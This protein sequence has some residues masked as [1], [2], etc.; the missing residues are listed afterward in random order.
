MG[1]TT[2]GE[3][4][5]EVVAAAK[6]RI[7]L[8]PMGRAMLVLYLLFFL[9]SSVM[10]FST[11]EGL[12]Y[13]Q[14]GGNTWYYLVRQA[15][16]FFGGL[17]LMVVV[18]QGRL[19]FYHRLDLLGVILMLGLLVLTL[20]FGVAEKGARRALSVFGLFTI[21]PAELASVPLIIYLASYFSDGRNNPRT[22][23][24]IL[25]PMVVIGA[26]CAVVVVNSLSQALVL[27]VVGGVMLLMGRVRW[28]Y[29]VLI[30]VMGLVG[31]GGY[32]VWSHQKAVQAEQRGEELEA[33]TTNRS[34][35][36]YNRFERWLNGTETQTVQSKMAIA[37]GVI[38]GKGPG[39]NQLS[40]L[41][42]ESYSDFIF[43]I[44]VEEYGLP[45]AVAVMVLYCIL[46]WKVFGVL[47]ASKNTF[48]QMVCGGV[49]V[50]IAVQVLINI[51][52][53]VGFMPVTGITL[54]LIS[55]GATSLLVV[56]V[57]LGLVLSVN[58]E[59]MYEK[60]Q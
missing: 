43:S 13:Y 22:L 57:M 41:L 51:M 56:S 28:W 3:P 34:T 10:V 32:Q 45:G 5:Q 18:G 15:L 30:V 55:H 42:P 20:K 17:V 24:G 35:T 36:R 23:R 14:Q 44:I 54:P 39:G 16:V 7:P 60:A 47:K 4:A 37:S 12:S 2:V 8:S 9:V 31:L 33:G 53:G 48:A 25:P 58:R 1:E 52:V 29:V 38:I 40:S 26:F 49:G 11:T 21:R 19:D 27:A 59:A 46:L 6:R 50:A